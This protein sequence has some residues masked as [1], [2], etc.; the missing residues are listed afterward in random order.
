VAVGKHGRLRYEVDDRAIWITFARPDELNLID[1]EFFDDL[2]DAF[3]LASD[4][5]EH[6]V[7]VLR[8]SGR[9]FSGGGNIK[10]GMS[11]KI[12]AGFT[13]ELRVEMYKHAHA[14]YPAFYAIE[15][16]PHTV[17]AV[18]NGDS[19]GAAT[20]LITQCDLVLAARGA[21]ICWA[22][23]G[24][25]LANPG[26][27]RLVRKIGVGPAKDVLFTARKVPVEELYE[28]GLVTRLCDAADLERATMAYVDEVRHTSPGSRRLV[29]EL[30]LR[31][32]PAYS[33][34]EHTS[35]AVSEDFR[36][37]VAAFTNRTHAPWSRPVDE[38]GRYVDGETS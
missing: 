37:A 31:G 24:H 7:V 30:I 14:D 19:Y 34:W 3:L 27:N 23:G 26:A 29:K 4:D 28:R 36:Q 22:Q 20:E 33:T 13:H 9:L 1:E 32:T 25:G 2:V 16:C 10:E 21:R 35:T 18:V 15:Q 5:T 8:G 38:H 6:S 11:A 17:I 12:A